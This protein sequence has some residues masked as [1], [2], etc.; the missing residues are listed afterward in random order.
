MEAKVGTLFDIQRFCLNDGPG[1]RTVVFFKGCPLRCA[2]CHNPESQQMRV[3]LMYAAHKCVGCQACQAACAHDAHSFPNGVHRVNFPE[4]V[5]CGACLEVCCY[6]ALT[7]TGYQAT[8]D[9][10]IDRIVPDFPYYGRDGGV[11]FSGGE[12]MLQPLFATALAKALCEKA[13]NVCMETSGYA[14]TGLFERIAPYIS[15]FLYDWKSTNDAV[16]SV[17]TGV[18]NRLPLQ[19]LTRLD[20]LG[21]DIILRCPMIPGVNNTEE[22]LRGI[23]ELAKRFAAIRHVELLPYHAMGETKRLQ[24]GVAG[25][26]FSAAIPTMEEKAG[27][28]AKLQEF[29]CQARFG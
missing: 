20:A 18:S 12:P 21:K 22:H 9:E 14:E 24:M 26:H 19:N 27:W 23:A 10:A 11:T 28:I 15:L 13:I 8:V 29:G 4:C 25:K 3:N 1:I 17:Y 16:H 6:G 7:L 2:W 5:A